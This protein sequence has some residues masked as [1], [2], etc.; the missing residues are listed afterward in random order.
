MLEHA[1]AELFEQQAADLPQARASVM[2]ATREGRALRGRRRRQIV[3]SVAAP[4]LAAVTVLALALAGVLTA[5]APVPPAQHGGPAHAAPPSARFL[6]L[7]AVPGWLPPA[8][9]FTWTDV[10]PAESS[11]GGMEP[12]PYEWTVTLYRSGGCVLRA[13]KLTC[14]V[15]NPG[16][17]GPFIHTYDLTGPAPGIRRLPADWAENAYFAK[18]EA[19]QYAPNS[20]AIA[21]FFGSRAD[22]GTVV[23]HLRFGRAVPL[24]RYPAQLTDSWPGLG[25]TDTG[26]GT[27]GRYSPLDAS[28]FNLGGTRYSATMIPAPIVIQVTAFDR[29]EC[30]MASIGPIDNGISTPVPG[31]GTRE[32]INGYRVAIWKLAAGQSRTNRWPAQEQ[33]CTPVAADG[34]QVEISVTG[35]FRDVSAASIFAHLKLFGPDP[36]DWTT[37]P[38]S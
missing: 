21:S 9:T 27:Y 17:L 37:R 3:V 28:G 25:L 23:R 10:T 32:I 11:I 24:L 1:L 14:P 5:A 16:H 38:I 13:P 29:G 6:R 33:L 8:Y 30:T 36:R 26:G 22:E 34:M 7:A 19:F 31:P 2:V 20:W 12:G 4:V 18:I 15:A 35:R